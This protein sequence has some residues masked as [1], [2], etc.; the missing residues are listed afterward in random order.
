MHYFQFNIGDYKS[1]THHLSLIEDI[2][3]RRLLD[4]YY[5]HEHPLS[6]GLTY[7]ARQVGMK[8]YESEIQAVLDEFFKLT[9]D[10]WINKRADEEIAHFKAK[11]QQ[12]SKAGKASAER[13]LSKRSTGVGTDVQPNIKQ[14]PI[15][16]KQEPSEKRGSKKCPKDFTVTDDMMSWARAECPLVNAAEQTEVFRDYEFSAARSDWLGTWRN[17]MRKANKY[18]AEKSPYQKTSSG[19]IAGAI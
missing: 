2:A 6:G 12:A 19:I 11:A 3:Y 4:Y 5:L 18:A 13:R 1:H 15:T 17:W 16:I 10:G 7:V 14:E 9:D 8:E